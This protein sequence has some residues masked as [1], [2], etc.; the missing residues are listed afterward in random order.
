MTFTVLRKQYFV[1]REIYYK[2]ILSS[3]VRLFLILLGVKVG[4]NFFARAFPSIVLD[5]TSS[6]FV[7][8]DVIFKGKVEIRA[9]N[10]ANV[11]LECDVR[12][13]VGVRIVATNKASVLFSS[14]SDI[15]CYSIFNCGD[16]FSIGRDCLVAG[17]CY[18][19]TSDHNTK[20]GISIK[21]QGYNHGAIRIGDDSWIAG[22]SFVLSGVTINDGCVVGANSV[23]NKPLPSNAIAVGSPAK[24]IETRR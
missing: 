15:G 2:Y 13:D 3:F 4:R 16:D 18:F 1:V 21:N 20:S 11:V 7:G 23:V 10:G 24:V 19:Q 5:E 22:G 6:L 9:V 17:F 8:D 12:L 14:G